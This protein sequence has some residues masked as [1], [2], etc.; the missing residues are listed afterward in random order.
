MKAYIIMGWLLLIAFAFDIQLTFKNMSK[1]DLTKEFKQYYTAALAPE[2]VTIEKG[3]FV[4]ITGKG[5][6]DGPMFS[7]V[8]AALCMQWHMVLSSA[9]SKRAATLL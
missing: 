8:T 6:P 5:D 9:A 4:T 2:L 7:E 3:P 1:L